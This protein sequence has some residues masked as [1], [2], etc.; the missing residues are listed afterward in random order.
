MVKLFERYIV[1]FSHGI[2]SPARGTPLSAAASVPPSPQVRARTAETTSSPQHPIRRQRSPHPHRRFA[3]PVLLSLAT[4]RPRTFV[5]AMATAIA[6][7]ALL[8]SASCPVGRMLLAVAP[9]K[10]ARSGAKLRERTQ[11]A[12]AGRSVRQTDPCTAAIFML[13]LRTTPC[14]P[15]ARRR[16]VRQI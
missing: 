3:I 8:L 15:G 13:A 10:R 9:G 16:G 11:P 1:T 4:W 2:S 12:P 14:R 5:C 7:E 6:L